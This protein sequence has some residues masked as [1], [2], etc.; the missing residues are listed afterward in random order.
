M[1]CLSRLLGQGFDACCWGRTRQGRAAPGGG[2]ALIRSRGCPARHQLRS[3]WTQASVS[4]SCSSRSRA[5][6]LARSSRRTAATPCERR[7]GSASLRRRST[8][9][10]SRG[11]RETGFAMP[12]SQASRYAARRRRPRS[13]SART[14]ATVSLRRTLSAS[15][16]GGLHDRAYRAMSCAITSASSILRPSPCLRHLRRSHAVARTVASRSVVM[17]SPPACGHL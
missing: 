8:A 5:Y 17:A 10:S 1:L 7:S 2:Q 15:R 11:L 12:Q 3:Y 4:V 9:S 14:S 16:P 6:R 13:C